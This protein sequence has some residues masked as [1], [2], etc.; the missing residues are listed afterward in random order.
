MAKQQV[1]DASAI[2]ALKGLEPVRRM[3]GMYTRTVH[4]LHIIQEAI[5]NAV[6]EALG[7]YGKQI[8][9]TLHADGSVRSTTTAAA[10]RSACTRWRRRRRSSS[11]SP[12]CMPAASSRQGAAATTFSGGLH[13][14][15]VSV[16]N[17]L[18]QRLEVDRHSATG[19]MHRIVF[20]GGEVTQKLKKRQ[21]RPARS[22]PA[23]WC[24]SGPIRNTSIRR[25]FRCPSSSAWCA[26]RPSCC[27]A[28][29]CRS[30]SKARKRRET[31]KYA[32]GMKQYLE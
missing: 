11:P 29:R 26:R 16:T 6:D 20:E 14:V 4:P 30:T 7:G 21:G 8:N 24:G 5:D 23:R 2:Q 28:S 22:A 31:W 32:R 3:P 25:T 1:Y 19:Q 12:C 27:P 15:G 18:V 13:G 10:F 9:V 17:A